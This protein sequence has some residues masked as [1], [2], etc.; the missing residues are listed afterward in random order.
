MKKED[1]WKLYMNDEQI[2]KNK[3]KNINIALL[4]FP[5]HGFGDIIYGQKLAN[6]LRDW[7]NCNVSIFTSL[8]DSHIKLGENPKN[9]RSPLNKHK[10]EECG[11]IKTLKFK[12]ND[13]DTYYDLYFIAPLVSEF[14]I[15]KNTIIKYF[16]YANKSNIFIFSE[17]NPNK[18]YKYDF[19]TG[20][21]QN[22]YGIFLNDPINYIK[23]KSIKNPYS[24]IYIA[25]PEHVARVSNCYISF[26]HMLCLKYYKKY[27]KLDI[28]VPEW[29]SKDILNNFEKFYN[30]ISL[31]Y[32]TIIFKYKDNEDIINVDNNI[33]NKNKLYIRSDILPLEHKNMLSLIKYSIDDI[34]LTGDQSI[35]D[36]ISCCHKKNIFYQ[37]A[38]WKVNFA[39]NIAKYL[40]NK[41]L[42]KKTTSCGSLNAIKL[43]SDYTNFIKKWDFRVLAKPKLDAIIKMSYSNLTKKTRSNSTKKTR[44]NSTKKTR[45]NSTKK[46]RSNSTKK[47]RSNSTKKTRSNSTKK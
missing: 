6:Y 10:N 27:K 35:T 7:Y 23:L 33:K 24:I 8:P 3:T 19:T 32:P 44:S 18:D 26:L 15:N 46:T 37:T 22:K 36:A 34:L 16:K 39:K 12:K 25:S 11:S 14:S 13:M 5:C 2:D 17:Y 31:Y 4:N 28:I 9:L 45:S 20:I 41:F 47:T 29:L 21:G 43:K 38:D 42:S 30:K 40:P 1:L